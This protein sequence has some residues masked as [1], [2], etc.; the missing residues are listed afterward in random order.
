MPAPR[1]E[2]QFG[3]LNGNSFNLPVLYFNHILCGHNS[4]L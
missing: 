3:Q 1:T 2:R 4:T